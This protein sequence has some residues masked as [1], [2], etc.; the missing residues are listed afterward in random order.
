MEI[1]RLSSLPYQPCTLVKSLN[2]SLSL[3][4]HEF[5]LSSLG[6]ELRVLNEDVGKH[7]GHFKGNL[8][9]LLCSQRGSLKRP[10]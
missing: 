1:L 6:K 9:F 3:S 8:A 5:N 4:L 7:L 2:T 10:L